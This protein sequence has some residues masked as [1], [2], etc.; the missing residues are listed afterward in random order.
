MLIRHYLIYLSL[1][2][3]SPA[4]GV[5]WSAGFGPG[6]AAGPPPRPFRLRQDETHRRGGRIGRGSRSAPLL[7]VSVQPPPAGE[8][9][10]C[11]YRAGEGSR[12]SPSPLP[13][14]AGQ[15]LPEG[16]LDRPGRPVRLSFPCPYH[17]PSHRGG[18]GHSSRAEEGG[19]PSP[20]PL[21]PPAGQIPARGDRIGQRGPIPPLPQPLSLSHSLSLSQHRRKG[22][23]MGLTRG[24]TGSK[25]ASGGG[26]GDLW[27]PLP[28]PSPAR[29]NEEAFVEEMVS[30]DM[31][32]KRGGGSK[33]HFAPPLNAL[34][35][36]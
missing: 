20:S 26:G 10:H 36:S 31:G 14:P 6:R 3:P 28:P 1:T 7:L 18:F 23:R 13:P 17:P 12:P 27:L 2:P 21:P 35:E 4:G 16:R 19:R 33:D 34:E 8:G 11:S 5:F 22:G 15:D 29:P 9:F 32:K 25:A 30:V 24:G